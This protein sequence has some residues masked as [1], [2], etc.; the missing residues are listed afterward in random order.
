M[1]LVLAMLDNLKASLNHPRFIG[2]VNEFGDKS[3]EVNW[4]SPQ[5]SSAANPT[6]HS[7]PR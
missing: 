5:K 4:S 2:F 6:Q 3:M 1:M 7:F